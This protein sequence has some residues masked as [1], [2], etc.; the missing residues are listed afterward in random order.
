MGPHTRLLPVHGLA[1][2]VAWVSFLCRCTSRLKNLEYGLMKILL[3]KPRYSTIYVEMLCFSRAT[4]SCI[5]EEILIGKQ[6]R[7]IQKQKRQ[8]WNFG[9]IDSLWFGN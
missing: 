1:S 5:D 4:Q 6:T 3:S 7:P 8:T 2:H 9:L